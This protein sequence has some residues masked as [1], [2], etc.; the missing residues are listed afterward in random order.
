[1]KFNN[2]T[3]ALLTIGCFILATLG[4]L[5][6][7]PSIFRH[8]DKEMHSLFY[9]L[10]AAFMNILF[11]DR[12]IVRHITIFISLYLFGVLIEYVQEY[13]NKLLHKRIHGRYDIED[14]Q[15]NF[16]GLLLYSAIW[17]SY[18]IA[19]FTHGKFNRREKNVKGQV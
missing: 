10:A 17:I 14:V 12:K 16:K 9:F 18:N 11:A 13:S 15:S 2:W 5:I 19:I 4:F 7:L 8:Y 1:M 6:K 3:K